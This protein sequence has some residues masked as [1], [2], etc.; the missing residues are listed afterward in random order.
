[1]RLFKH[2]CP[3]IHA[4]ACV[5]PFGPLTTDLEQ[6]AT[7]MQRVW[8]VPMLTPAH[9]YILQ[10]LTVAPCRAQEV[11]AIHDIGQICLIDQV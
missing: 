4:G 9:E 10:F 2:Q 7:V 8:P 11:K 5:Y 1:M 6:S 3:R